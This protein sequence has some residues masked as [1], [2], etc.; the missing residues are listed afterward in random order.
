MT[1]R[2]LIVGSFLFLITQHVVAQQDPG[3]YQPV[4]KRWVLRSIGGVLGLGIENFGAIDLDGFQKFSRDRLPAPPSDINTYYFG[5]ASSSFGLI[6]GPRLALARYD[7]STVEEKGWLL[8]AGM[9]VRL[10]GLLFYKDYAS[11]DTAYTRTY[12]Y[13]LSQAEW[14]LGG[15]RYWRTRADRSFFLAASGL[16]ELAHT[17]SSGI[18]INGDLTAEYGGTDTT[19][20]FLSRTAEA[21]AQT[22]LRLYAAGNAG[23]RIRQRVDLS[24]QV[25]FGTGLMWLHGIEV[26]PV[27]S[28]MVYALSLQ[29][30]IRR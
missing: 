26:R 29:W 13:V 3:Y 17:Y 7:G 23:F 27:L 5:I 18:V 9:N 2:A 25:Q 11:G 22:F 16:G 1:R 19:N 4:T 28:S 15:G 20:N 24:A 12:T 14:A 10:F 8:H 6:M 30:L 21:R